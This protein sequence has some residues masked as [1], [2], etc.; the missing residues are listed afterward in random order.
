MK[1]ILNP[2]KEIVK[3]I[4]L[5]SAPVVAASLSGSVVALI[6]GLTVRYQ[7]SNLLTSN[8]DMLKN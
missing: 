5:I 8:Y 2:D 7:L 6:D 1:V 3:K 4:I